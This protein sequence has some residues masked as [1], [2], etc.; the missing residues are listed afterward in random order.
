[1]RM[2]L[3]VHASLSHVASDQ[4]F[5]DVVDLVVLPIMPV[6][7]VCIVPVSVVCVCVCICS[8][9]SVSCLY[10]VFVIAR[11]ERVDDVERSCGNVVADEQG[12]PLALRLVSEIVR[13][14]G[15][16]GV[17]LVLAWEH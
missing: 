16:V 3:L 15:V 13:A 6:V 9:H 2:V 7:P 1:M 10:I 8:R 4:F 17:E 12:V 11:R 5:G 14:A